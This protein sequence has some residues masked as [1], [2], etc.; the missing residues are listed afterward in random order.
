MSKII[1][2]KNHFAV[3][4]ELSKEKNDFHNAKSR[5]WI[6]NQYLGDYENESP[7]Y[8]VYQYLNYLVSNS[9]KFVTLEFKGMRKDFRCGK[10]KRNNKTIEKIY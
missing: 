9:N 8:G 6:R 4:L 2:N 3:E 10:A 7:I 5:I 1:G